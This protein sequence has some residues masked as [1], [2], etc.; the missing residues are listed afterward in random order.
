MNRYALIETFAT[1][2]LIIDESEQPKWKY[3]GI[4]CN[5]D[6]EKC[7]QFDFVQWPMIGNTKLLMC[8]FIPM[9]LYHKKSVNLPWSEELKEDNQLVPA[10]TEFLENLSQQLIDKTNEI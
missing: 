5:N 8:V 2:N 10:T 3:Q 1:P 7:Y 4:G 9:G 6:G